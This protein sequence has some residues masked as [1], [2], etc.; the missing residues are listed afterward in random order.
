MS[1]PDWRRRFSLKKEEQDNTGRDASDTEHC[2]EV[3][4][5]SSPSMRHHPVYDC[6][7]AGS[8]GPYPIP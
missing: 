2:L 1:E 8:E 3:K 5:S 4:T 7:I 6:N